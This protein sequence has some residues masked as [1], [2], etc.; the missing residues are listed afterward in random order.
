MG[1]FGDGIGVGSDLVLA[2]ETAVAAALAPLGGRTPDLAVVFACGEAADLAKAGERACE[3]TGAAAAIG[4]S[5]A[6]VIGGG[7]GV[8]GSSAV[9][10]FVGVL[11][12]A[13]LRTF[14]LEVMP[15]ERGA[16]VIGLPEREASGDEVALLLADPY[17][18]PV[19]GFVSQAA[20]TLA[21]LPFV[22]GMA[23]GGSGAGSTR[24]W[25]DGR[26]VDRGAVGVLVDGSS[27]R[28]LVSQGCRPVG[29]AM[30]VTE[31]HGNVIRGLAGQPALEKMRQVLADLPPPEQALASSGLHLGIAAD[32][33]A[34]DHEYLV[35]SI[36]GTEPDTKGLVVGDL[37]AVGQTVRLQIRDADAADADLRATLARCP[38]QPGS[39]ALLFSCNGR[40]AH[41]FG[42]SYGG[43]SHDTAL[44]RSSLAADAVA[45]FFADGEIGP[46]A[47]RSHLHG[48]TASVLVFP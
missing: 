43:A 38:G 47:G 17:S 9:S 36:T 26:T 41:L 3:L 23:H 20:K 6:G 37:V 35:R 45:G 22:G 2:A 30:T 34:E 46:V 13:S 12:G 48:F 24:L 14:H 10:V 40:G 32:E 33:Y 7:K 15:A 4:C 5:G 44:V 8:E 1:R 42:P 25:I 16:A 27:A 39:G 31:A 18:F 29:P 28:S 21:G 11:P 19:D